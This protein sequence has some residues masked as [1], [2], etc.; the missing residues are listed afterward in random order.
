MMK[1]D[2]K[3]FGNDPISCFWNS[4]FLPC[5]LI[6]FGN[7]LFNHNKIVEVLL[8]RHLFD[9]DS[10]SFVSDNSL[11]LPVARARGIQSA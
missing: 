1:S 6:T 9:T 3:K 4:G 2:V 10:L 11:G 8:A 7:Q 5:F